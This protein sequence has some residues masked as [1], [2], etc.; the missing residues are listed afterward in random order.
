MMWSWLILAVILLAV[1][2][3]TGTVAL[4]FAGVGALAAAAAAFFAP[5]VFAAQGSL[6]ALAA[7]IGVGVAWRRLRAGKA[8]ATQDVSGTDVAGQEVIA[9]TAADT[10]DHLR[11]RHRG[12]DWNARLEPAVPV[13]VGARLF[14]VRQEGSTLVVCLAQ[15]Q[16]EMKA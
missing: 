13:A 5:E 4:L 16:Q 9:A 12:C 2:M 3:M 10:G 15:A 14:I 7:L 1:E 6:F 8:E 11:V